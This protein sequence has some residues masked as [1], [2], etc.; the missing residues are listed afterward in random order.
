MSHKTIHQ[1]EVAK[2]ISKIMRLT[3][4]CPSLPVATRDDKLYMVYHEAPWMSPQ[5]EDEG[6]CKA[7]DHKT[8][9]PNSEGLLKAKLQMIVQELI[10]A[11]ASDFLDEGA[12]TADREKNEAGKSS[13]SIS[14]RKSHGA[15]M[16]MKRRVVSQP[17]VDPDACHSQPKKP[18]AKRPQVDT[19]ES[20][21]ATIIISSDD[22]VTLP[23][24]STSATVLAP[25]KPPGVLNK[26]EKVNLISSDDEVTQPRKITSNVVLVP[27]KSTCGSSK[28]DKAKKATKVL[29]NCPLS[30]PDTP[31]NRC[32]IEVTSA[33]K[34]FRCHCGQKMILLRAGRS[35]KA[36]SHWNT[37]LYT[38]E[39]VQLP[40]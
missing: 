22:E 35:E 25:K 14:A 16:V 29:D 34:E 18:A 10:K 2:L 3:Q 38:L 20:K 26:I 30:T 15:S 19:L 1:P 31:C 24:K 37:M 33:D 12:T 9:T 7:R 8:W 23:R 4:A 21:E 5:D 28:V 6:I 40:S 13:D 17:D 11:G 27:K 39:N 32:K 36:L